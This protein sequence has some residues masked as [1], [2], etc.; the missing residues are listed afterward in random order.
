MSYIVTVNNNGL[1]FFL[2]GTIWA[3][4]VD[5]AQ[6]FTDRE[7]AELALQKARKFMKASIFKKA[8]IEQGQMIDNPAQ[9]DNV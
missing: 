2:R 4:T 6:V 8:R 7:S 3:Y 9:I 5:R 1:V